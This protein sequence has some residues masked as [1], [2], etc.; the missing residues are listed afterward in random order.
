M[1]STRIN[2]IKKKTLLVFMAVLG[3]GCE[4][5]IS[6]DVEFATLSTTGEIFT[7]DFIGL[8]ED[9]FRP[10]VGDGAKPDVFSVD[11]T[12]GYESEASIRIDVPNADDPGG[13]F[14][15]ASFIIDGAARNLTEFDALTFWARASQAATIG[16]LGFGSAFKV[17][18]I[19]LDFTTQWQQFIIPIPDPSKLTEVQTVFEFSAGGIGPEGQELGYTFWIDELKFEKL[20]T[21][22]QPRPSILAGQNIAID[23]FVGQEFSL[24][25]LNQTFNLG[26]GQNQTTSV[27]ASY[28]TFS[29]SS[30]NVAAVNENGMVSVFRQ[31][32]TEVT[33]IL[34]GVRAQGSLSLNVLGAF[35]SA[36]TPPA[37]E[38]ADV[39][40]VFSDTY[41]SLPELNIAV[42]NGPG[43]PTGE[44][45]FISTTEFDG[46]SI[47]EYGNLDFVG[48]G[49]E[50]NVDVSGFQFLHIDVQVA[51]G[52]STSDILNVQIIDFG[53][54]GIDDGQNRVDDTGG[55]FN[56]PADDLE[57]DVWVPIDIPLDQFT[58]PTGGGFAGS[59]NLTNVARVV[60]VGNLGVANILVDNIYFYRN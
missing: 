4:R 11:D 33:A 35:V 12:E 44:S 20:G 60:F 37:R 22:A 17:A 31:G 18:A 45:I 54:N 38:P 30:P 1:K 53:A 51:Q 6:D 3:V 49:W 55:G 46:N 50:G 21:I 16:S 7:D 56:I 15:G 9:F 43:F 40:S 58:L 34:N 24:I 23:A 8:G 39:I 52:L 48:I 59:P 26:N 2:P 14:A 13:N 57:E 47:I 19:D 32:T 10:F 5:S 25:P 29:S 36:P 41:E 27:A 28:F 42:F